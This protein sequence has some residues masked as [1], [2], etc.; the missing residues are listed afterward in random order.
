[1]Q[2]FHHT[3]TALLQNAAVTLLRNEREFAH[4][5]RRLLA[6][7]VE[8]AG[9]DDLNARPRRLTPFMV[10]VVQ[11]P[12]EVRAVPRP[13]APPPHPGAPGPPPD[14]V[15]RR[16]VHWIDQPLLR[17]LAGREVELRAAAPRPTYVVTLDEP[18]LGELLRSSPTLAACKAFQPHFPPGALADAETEL[19]WMAIAPGMDAPL[20]ALTELLVAAVGTQFGE[21]A[22]LVLV[23]GP[24][25]RLTVWRETAWQEVPLAAGATVPA[26][27]Q[28]FRVA[29]GRA[30]PARLYFACTRELRNAPQPTPSLT[31]AAIGDRMLAGQFHRVVYVCARE[32][33]RIPHGLATF[34]RPILQTPRGDGAIL[35]SFVGCRLVPPDPAGGTSWLAS[36]CRAL[37]QRFANGFRTVPLDDW[38]RD[39]A[40]NAMPVARV[41]HRLRKDE[42]RLAIDAGVLRRERDRW[43]QG[44]FG[45]KSFP[46]AMLGLGAD[47]DRPSAEQLHLRETA[48][49]WAR[50]VT[51]RRVGFAV[52][53]GGAC[54]Y[55]VVPL[56]EMLRHRGVPIDLYSGAS[57][58]SLLGAYYCTHGVAGLRLARERGWAFFLTSLAASAWSGTLEMQVDAD[59]GG[60]RIEDLE[61]ILLPVTTA[62]GDPPVASVVV[63][64][65]LGE[66]VRASGSALGSFG[67]TR[68]GPVRYADGTT[69]TMVPAKVLS[70]HGAD[71]VLAVNCV[72]GPLHGNPLGGYMIGRCI[73]NLPLF[74]RM[75]D[76][77]VGGSYLLTT[78]SR[79]AGTDAQVYW[80][81]S[82]VADPLFEA[83]FFQCADR[84]V[85]DSMETDGDAMTK[86]TD[87][88]LDLWKHLGR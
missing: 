16:G 87:R 59:L 24:A 67:P 69:A 34:L 9:V 82:P 57:G 71:L 37:P 10:A 36:I 81:P 72:P 66:A 68:K 84:I 65:T 46:A 44:A 52:S 48:F 62:L 60:T 49:R 58:G 21:P 61:V 73:Y 74:G 64:G 8:H 25:A 23:D 63:G 31:T 51:N 55:R 4:A 26:I 85:A 33:G 15:L 29:V 2:N 22:G 18:T 40:P 38:P 32:L 43:K 79:M 78:A 77:W 56:I 7:V 42:C 83:P 76:L 54:A 39:A 75:I 17:P 6:D 45:A 14:A 5:S 1:M 30:G 88:M 28:A 11:G 13:D 19:V 35:S 50:A 20:V 86:V 27:A 12:V 47:A 41:R 80:E 53:G 70:D 3:T